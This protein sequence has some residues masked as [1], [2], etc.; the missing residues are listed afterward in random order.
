MRHVLRGLFLALGGR[1][2][3]SPAV[4]RALLSLVLLA[5]CS[6]APPPDGPIAIRSTA[7]GLDPTDPARQ[8]AGRL[9]FLGGL[10]LTSNDARLGGISGLRWLG[11]SNAGRLL[12]VTDD[13]VWLQLALRES[14]D[15]L[16][17]IAAATAGQLHGLDGKPLASRRARDAESLTVVED[18]TIDTCEPRL[19]IVGFEHDHRIWSYQLAADG[20]PSGPASDTGLFGAWLSRQAE[21]G[22]IEALAGSAASFIVAVSEDARDAAG[23]SEARRLVGGNSS[24][25]LTGE[26]FAFTI[27]VPPPYKPTDADWAEAGLILLA[28]DYAP[29]RGVSAV[30][31]LVDPETGDFAE[32]AQLKP[33]LSVDNF[34]AVAV[35]QDGARTFLYLASDNN[36]SAAQRT[37]LLKF[38]LLEAT[39]K[40]GGNTSGRP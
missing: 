34:E 9:R 3:V 32:I 13:G 23:R 22:G 8:T 36:F 4:M 5:A 17:G 25:V 7:V 30:I 15:R 19:A 31:G 21:N 35:R 6:A 1:G 29:L 27:A 26:E 38:E 12:A 2:S 33:P 18:C 40:A 28:R 14:D 37:L 39:Q 16:A 10:A 20:T 11:R 24:D